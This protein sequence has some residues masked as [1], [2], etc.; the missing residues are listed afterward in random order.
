V[1]VQ[2]FASRLTE[3]VRRTPSTTVVDEDDET[4]SSEDV[5]EAELLELAP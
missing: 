4:P 5:A 3:T 1:T 2:P